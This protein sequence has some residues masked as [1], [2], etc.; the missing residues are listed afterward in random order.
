[1]V[2]VINRLIEQYILSLFLFKI[3]AV[4]HLK[5]EEFRI[6][7][8]SKKIVKE[9]A[10]EKIILF[11]SY[12]NG[13]PTEDSDIDLIIVNKTT[14]PKNKRGI[15]IRRL[16]YRQL[17]P[18]DIKVYTPQEFNH[19]LSNRFSFLYSAMKNSIVLY[20]R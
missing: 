12:A 3:F 10:P 2:I 8:I 19:E 17:I 5:K 9:I 1:L 14:M 13:T 7:E 16:F 4:E 15:E 11:G 20:E 6:N 18:L